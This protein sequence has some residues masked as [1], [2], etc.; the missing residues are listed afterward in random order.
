MISGYIVVESTLISILKDRLVV[1]LEENFREE[2][3]NMSFPNQSFWMGKSDGEMASYDNASKRSHQWLLDGFEAE[4]LPNKKHAA[5]LSTSNLFSEVI[6]SNDPAW[7]NNFCFQPV[8][9]QFTERLFDTETA[10]AA[11]IKDKNVHP[12]NI[13]H[14]FGLSMS[15]TLDE[16]SKSGV[17]Y[18]GIRKVKI[19][20]VKESDSFVSSSTNA[21]NYHRTDNKAVSMTNTYRLDENAMCMGL[22]FGE[23]ENMIAESY[24]RETGLFISMGQPYS[25]GSDENISLASYNDDNSFASELAFDKV[26]SNLISMGQ[27]YNHVDENAKGLFVHKE[28]TLVGRDG[29]YN[30]NSNVVQDSCNKGQSTIISFGGSNDDAANNSGYEF[31]MSQSTPHLSETPTSKD[32]VGCRTN[33][34]ASS[35]VTFSNTDVSVK[36]EETKV[37]KKLQN[38]SFPS[39]VRSLLSTGMLDGVPVKYI[40]WSRE[41]ELHGVIKG[42]GYQCGC[43][44]CNSSK[45]VNAYEFERHAGCKTKHPNNHIYFENGKTIYGIVQELR[46][47]PQDLLFS[48]IPTMT[49]STINQ[50][51]FRLWKES[52]LAA[53]RELQRI[54]GKE[55]GYLL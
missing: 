21:L 50:K 42:S 33:V 26:D 31:L 10:S 2:L 51:S 54:Y 55:E 43:D 49:G 9:C 38:N 3:R 36:K 29:V 40:A 48:V 24:E 28:S 6:N 12:V 15:H 13:D 4:L 1:T 53:T 19:S 18:G 17:S 47:T 23:E 22:A 8:P 39:N 20:Q 27:S 16:D 32:L 41:K 45:V 25:K 37:S 14:S 44:S 35:E 34:L 7:G 5:E 52:Y 46:N 11:D 30:R